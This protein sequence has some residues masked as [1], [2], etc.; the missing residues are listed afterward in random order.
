LSCDPARCQWTVGAGALDLRDL[1]VNELAQR[2]EAGYQ[3]A[4]LEGAVA[5]AVRGGGRARL[6]EL[7]DLLERTP[8]RDDWPYDEP[9]GLDQIL[10][11]LPE[12]PPPQPGLNK[13]RLHDRLLGAWLGRCAGCLLGKPVE[14]WTY[15]QLRHDLELT[16]AYPLRAY[17]PVLRPMPE[18][19]ELRRCWPE[20]TQGHI[21]CMARDDDIDFTIL[22]LHILE[23]HGLGFQTRDVAAE[24]LDHLLFTQTYTAERVALRNLIDGLLP[25]RRPA[26]ATPT[27]SGSVPASEPTSSAMSRRATHTVPPSWPSGTPPC[28]TPLTASTA[29]CGRLR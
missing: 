7:L 17:V 2:R 13:V 28:P 5:A 12:A 26:T 29:R 3:V 22:G 27:G 11:R 8:R 23:T 19:F 10:A 16:G 6:E 14:G 9:A 24:W 20:A 25:Q 18:G 21:R 1:L 15:R 4:E